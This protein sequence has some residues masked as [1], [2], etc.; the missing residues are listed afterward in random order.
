MYPRVFVYYSNQTLWERFGGGHATY[1]L[2]SYQCYLEHNW[3][4]SPI[5]SEKPWMT[6]SDFWTNHT[7]SVRNKRTICSMSINE[8]DETTYLVTYLTRIKWHLNKI[9]WKDELQRVGAHPTPPLHGSSLGRGSVATLETPKVVW[10]NW[11]KKTDT[12]LE[13]LTILSNQRKW[14]ETSLIYSFG[15]SVQIFSC[16]L[17]Q[18]CEVALNSIHLS[19]PEPKMEFGEAGSARRYC[20]FLLCCSIILGLSKA[21][22]FEYRRIDY[23]GESSRFM[24]LNRWKRC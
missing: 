13:L 15:F 9:V 3:I 1:L 6:P 17:F 23:R 10:L 24:Q 19:S 12:I 4:V 7:L 8:D 20:V 16:L 2:F 22:H 18:W 21:K 11:W 5:G 14:G